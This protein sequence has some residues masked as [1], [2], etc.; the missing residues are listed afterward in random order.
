MTLR[1]NRIAGAPPPSPPAE[2]G[3]GRP[4]FGPAGAG[5]GR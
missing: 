4:L 3:A 2:G 5:D 1:E